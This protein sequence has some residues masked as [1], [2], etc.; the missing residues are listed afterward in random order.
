MG[1]SVIETTSIS[2]SRP[3]TCPSLLCNLF[4]HKPSEFTKVGESM[5]MEHGYYE[6]PR[7]GERE[8]WSHGGFTIEFPITK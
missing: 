2:I 5:G 8:G 3:P 1:C 4:G 7:C 6:C